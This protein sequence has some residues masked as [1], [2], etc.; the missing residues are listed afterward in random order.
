[1]KRKNTTWMLLIGAVLLGGFILIFERGS[2]TSY[3]QEQRTRT[4]FAVY[5]DS[6]ERILLERDGIQIECTKTAGGWR[7]TKPA[8]A[9][10]DSGLVEKMIAGLARVERGELITAKTLQERNLTPADY[11]FDTPRASITFKNN[12]GTFTWLIGRNAPVGKTLY[13]MSA[14]GDDIISAPQTLLNLVPQDPSWIR[15]RTIFS[16]EPAA[17]RGLDLR[18]PEGFLQLRQP[19]NNGWLIQQPHAGRA[20]KPSVHMLI[21]KILS[22][23][24]ADFITDE[25]ADL[26]A[27][28]LEKPAYELTVFMQDERTQTLLVGSPLPE[29]PEL[30]Y[31]KRIENDSVFTVPAEWVK[32]FS[33]DEDLLR[34]RHVLG[35]QPDRITAI[36]LTRNEQQIELIRTNNQWQVIRPVRWD[37]DPSQTG[38]LLKALTG[39]DV[40]EFIDEPSVAQKEQMKTAPW[41]AVLTADGKTNTLHIS[42]AA[43][44]MRMVQYNEEPAFYTTDSQIVRKTFADPLFYRSRI[45]LEVNPSLIQ[46]ITVQ[47]SGTEQSVQKTDV[48]I[49]ASAQP[50]RQVSAKA[51][52]DIMW[53][54]NDLCADRYVDF[55]PVSLKPYG[56]DLPQTSLTVTLS[57]TNVIGRIVLLGNKAE[58]GRF[59]M[60]QGQN[61]VFVVS[62][63][64]AQTLT[65]ELTVPIEK[66]AEEIK[67]P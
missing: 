14:G 9:P 4:V 48:G 39:A 24:I 40:A 6:I 66:Q 18:R 26:T 19:E 11:G 1:M 8:D 47:S 38:E 63:E 15:D 64:T 35:L 37:A 61:I 55:N 16:G 17:V 62:E 22:G 34:S 20:D 46:K 65:R 45:V 5:P 52:A 41:T 53:A 3:Q 43:N 49:F 32:E 58:D 10:L 42:E 57:D 54:L 21:E 29:K 13:V 25:K 56:L 67:Q 27:Y 36:Q 60:I 51:L 7:L 30:L 31:A 44:G 50:D 12:H 33:V 59:A 2:E 23:R 28:G